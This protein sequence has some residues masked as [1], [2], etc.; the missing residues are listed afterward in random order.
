MHAV[1]V[2][3]ATIPKLHVILAENPNGVL[4]VR[5]E[6]AGGS[7]CWTPRGAK[8]IGHSCSKPGTEMVTSLLIG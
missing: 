7:R 1:R 8:P 2:N 4:Y 6:L 5:D 3:D